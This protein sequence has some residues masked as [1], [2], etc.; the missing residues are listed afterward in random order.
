MATVHSLMGVCVDFYFILR[1]LIDSLAE[2]TSTWLIAD[3]WLSMSIVDCPKGE[4]FLRR[5]HSV[6]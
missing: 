5:C 2:V 1:L 3:G 4:R 6:P